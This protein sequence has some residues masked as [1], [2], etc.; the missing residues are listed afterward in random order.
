MNRALEVFY[1]PLVFL[2][3]TL[4]GGVHIADRVEF[5]RPPLSA[6][7]LAVLL[8]SALIRCGAV[9]PQRLMH[10]ARSPLQNVSGATVLITLFSA[11]VQAFNSV[12][13]LLGLPRI[14]VIVFLCVLLLNTLAASTDRTHGLRSLAVIFGSMF[15][16]K[17]IVLS[18][19][20]DP[21][22]GWLKRVLLAT[23]EGVTLGTLTQQPLAPATGYIAFLTLALFL[24]GLALL[25][26]RD[27]GDHG[28]A[29]ISTPHA[30]RRT[31]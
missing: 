30:M 25:P 3:V 21:A 8:L 12:T 27:D 23:V 7:V 28:R 20:S 15:V 22:G 11:S 24:A 5:V 29:R 19:L 14:V 17:F 18:A 2:T 10:P 4:L 16:L 13:P 6:L 9:A 26:R 31:E 1:V